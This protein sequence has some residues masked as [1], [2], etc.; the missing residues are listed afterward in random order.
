MDGRIAERASIIILWRHQQRASVRRKTD[1]WDKKLSSTIIIHVWKFSG[2]ADFRTSA[3]EDNAWRVV[4]EQVTSGGKWFSATV[5][6]SFG[7]LP[8]LRCSGNQAVNTGEILPEPH[9][10]HVTDDV[11]MESVC[12]CDI[13][14]IILESLLRRSWWNS[15]SWN[16]GWWY[17]RG[18][19][20]CVMLGFLA[21]LH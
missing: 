21:L 12:V 19:I 1:K 17:S 2:E 20:K 10:G 13:V 5:I 18:A 11:Y 8:T 16:V 9:W 3:K 14:T 15:L 6:Y 7:T 4:A